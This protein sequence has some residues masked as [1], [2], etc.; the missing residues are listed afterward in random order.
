VSNQVESFKTSE[1]CE[2]RMNLLLTRMRELEATSLMLKAH[3]N[4]T[5]IVF[6]PEVDRRRRVLKDIAEIAGE[7]RRVKAICKRLRIA[8]SKADHKEW[9]RD[10][11]AE[12]KAEL[13]RS[14]AVPR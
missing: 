11:A 13:E 12:L 14:L 1:E 7:Y 4:K 9:V 3:L 2:Q 5:R 6:G 8:E 10:L